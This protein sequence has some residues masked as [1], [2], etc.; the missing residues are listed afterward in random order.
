MASAV[1]CSSMTK[2]LSTIAMG[3]YPM[4]HRSFHQPPHCAVDTGL[5]L[6]RELVRRASAQANTHGQ[7]AG[8]H[9]S[10]H[11]L[12][13]EDGVRLLTTCRTIGSSNVR[14]NAKVMATCCTSKIR[15]S[16]AAIGRTMNEKKTYK[17]R[18]T[19]GAHSPVRGRGFEHKGRNTKQGGVRW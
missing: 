17:M 1:A 2:M 8:R 11:H 5:L 16:R 19:F 18:H 10:D 12:A 6:G 9:F 3:A 15:I 4:R 7:L 13:L 14:R